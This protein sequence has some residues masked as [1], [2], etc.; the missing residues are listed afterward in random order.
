[1]TIA[2]LIKKLLT[3]VPL[4][5]YISRKNLCNFEPLS[6][7]RFQAKTYIYKM[8]LVTG[9][10]GLAGSHLLLRLI[11]NGENVRAIYRNENNIQKAKSVFELYKKADLFEKIEMPLIPILADM[12]WKGILN[13][14]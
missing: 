8:I 3:S 14:N 1:M 13:Y 5:L 9:G 11:E 12:E 10:T 6:L 4:N 2:I 7:C